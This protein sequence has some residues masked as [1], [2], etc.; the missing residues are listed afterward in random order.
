MLAQESSFYYIQKRHPP[1]L[2]SVFAPVLV[3][4]YHVVLLQHLQRNLLPAH[5]VVIVVVVIK[6]SNPSNS[7]MP[8][9]L[10]FPEGIRPNCAG[11]G[12]D[13]VEAGSRLVVADSNLP[14]AVGIDPVDSILLVAALAAAV[15]GSPYLGW[16]GSSRHYFDCRW[17]SGRRDQVVETRLAA[18]VG[19]CRRQEDDRMVSTLLLEVMFVLVSR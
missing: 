3:G 6:T 1:G 8:D 10:K 11:L 15:D 12:T 19:R 5:V 14:V 9:R 13:H 18:A 7:N 2:A 16:I 4:V 17:G